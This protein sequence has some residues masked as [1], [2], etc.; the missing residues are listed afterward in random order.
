MALGVNAYVMTPGSAITDKA[1]FAVF[2]A[3]QDAEVL[4]SIQAFKK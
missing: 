3:D 2:G 4:A 1:N